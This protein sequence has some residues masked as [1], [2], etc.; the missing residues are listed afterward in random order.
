MPFFSR[1]SP[2][3]IDFQVG[4]TSAENTVSTNSPLGK[5]L[6]VNSWAHKLSGNWIRRHACLANNAWLKRRISQNPIPPMHFG[7]SNLSQAIQ[8]TLCCPPSSLDQKYLI[9]CMRSSQR[10]AGNLKTP[11]YICWYCLGNGFYQNF[12][13][14]S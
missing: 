14:T 11:H 1:S 8:C 9:I 6:A 3:S 10:V 12:F 13:C 4:E 5:Y 7:M 2:C